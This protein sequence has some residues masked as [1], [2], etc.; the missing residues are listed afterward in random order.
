MYFIS[1]FHVAGFGH[2]DAWYDGLTFDFRDRADDAGS[3]THLI[4]Q[5]PNGTG[6]TSLLGAM[7]SVFEPDQNQFLPKLA[8]PVRQ[9]K[10]YLDPG[11][12]PSLL[13]IE[14]KTDG[15][16]NTVVIGNVSALRDGAS[17]EVS[18][19]YFSYRADANGGMFDGRVSFDS[20]P[21]L[22]DAPGRLDGW[23]QWLAWL[24][25][26]RK[27]A[28]AHDWFQTDNQT[29]WNRNLTKNFS[30]D[31]ALYRKM[32]QFSRVE[33]G[34]D[35][36][37]LSFKTQTD[38]LREFMALTLPEELLADAL[39]LVHSESAR[40]KAKPQRE[41]ERDAVIRLEAAFA[42]FAEQAAVLRAAEERHEAIDT[43]LRRLAAAMI[44]IHL[45]Q[46]KRQNEL[47][48]LVKEMNSRRTGA[49]RQIQRLDLNLD[50]VRETAFTMNAKMLAQNAEEMKRRRDEARRS[51]LANK[52]AQH[53][54]GIELLEQ[55]LGDVQA[56]I[57]RADAGLKNWRDEATRV[58]TRYACAVTVER[59]R[60]DLER[61][62]LKQDL[63]HH[64]ASIKNLE[65]TRT[66]LLERRT[67]LK[68][69]ADGLEREL[70]ALRGLALTLVREGWLAS[71][72]ELAPDALARHQAAVAEAE[73][74]FEAAETR[75]QAARSRVEALQDAAAQARQT[76][77]TAKKAV[78][79]ATELESTISRQGERLRAL[80]GYALLGGAGDLLAASVASELLRVERD[81]H[82]KQIRTDADAA[83][84]KEAIEAIDRTRLAPPPPDTLVVAEHL[85]AAGITSAKPHL[86]YLAAVVP[87]RE[88]ATAVYL[89]DPARFAGVAIANPKELEAARRVRF[90]GLSLST[91]V[92][93]SA[94]TNVAQAPATPDGFVVPPTRAA[95]YHLDSAEAE[96]QTLE[97]EYTRLVDESDQVM[98]SLKDLAALRK[99][100][101]EVR[102][103]AGGRTLADLRYATQ[104]A[105][106]LERTAASAKDR[107]ETA[108]ADAK[109]EREEADTARRA[110]A[111]RKQDLDRGSHRLTDY[112]TR[113]EA[114]RDQREDLAGIRLEQPQ[115]EESFTKTTAELQEHRARADAV[116]ERRGELN[117]EI[118][119]LHQTL[120][121]IAYKQDVTDTVL[122]E[123]QLVPKPVAD[124]RSDY[125]EAVRLLDMEASQK[126]GPLREQEVSTKTA[127][128]ERR[129]EYN[130]HYGSLEPSEM[131]AFRQ[132]DHD[133]EERRL[134]TVEDSSDREREAFQSQKAVVDSGLEQL[135][136]ERR[137]KGRAQ[138][139]LET[140]DTVGAADKRVHELEIEIANQ[141]KIEQTAAAQLH[142]HQSQLTALTPIVKALKDKIDRHK[143]ED[144]IRNAAGVV[145]IAQAE[146]LAFGDLVGDEFA[147]TYDAN[148]DVL[149]EVQRARTESATRYGQFTALLG[150]PEITRSLK[151][152]MIAGLTRNS[153]EEAAAEAE[154]LAHMLAARR[155]TI[156]EDLKELN[157]DFTRI[158]REIE[159]VADEASSALKKAGTKCVPD[160]I[161]VYG[162]Q[163]ILKLAT[164]RLAVPQDVRFARLE[165]YL[166][167]LV[168]TEQ[169]PTT[170]AQLAAEAVLEFTQQDHL[171]VRILKVTQ[172]ETLDYLPVHALGS[173][174]GEK[175]VAAVLLWALIAKLKRE[176]GREKKK[177]PVG[178]LIIDNIF[179]QVTHEALLRLLRSMS[180]ALKVQ[181]I[182]TSLY[183]DPSIAAVFPKMLHLRPHVGRHKT[184]HR[185]HVEFADRQLVNL[186]AKLRAAAENAQTASSVPAEAGAA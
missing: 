52:A 129:Q 113:S 143:A 102:A 77:Q 47:D 3:P 163:P 42:G 106:Q 120:A 90:D 176:H 185:R 99:D 9:F 21:G 30:V 29:D 157:A 13:A 167:R 25:T 100:L 146:E 170:G 186:E 49:Q 84:V 2:K 124:A 114:A 24:K 78:V 101:E 61:G 122:R 151:P 165:G 169:L 172:H 1:R 133:A 14:L 134:A 128:R 104:E 67:L 183:E 91:P 17:G 130:R 51:R 107:S 39:K 20:L 103:R 71:E 92:V 152:L 75:E 76:H 65:S 131:D 135:R 132:V 82:A 88:Q 41:A 155:M 4:L 70:A 74:A 98:C 79:A 184:T 93:V 111:K 94:A 28:A 48:E 136:N 139:S 118:S 60:L 164:D 58:G 86:G 177:A 141:K 69:R 137:A 64:E 23:D 83:R 12:R 171:N 16:S 87:E 54:I 55:R 182:F 56:E 27:R 147:A 85:R 18:R 168:T 80:P 5:A 154:H 121:G 145:W 117:T 158:V 96:R 156:I 53:V 142:V 46:R 125:E 148:V 123:C 11:G 115:V 109:R 35:K 144:L 63:E 108:L 138:D 31:V 22:T 72:D 150:D 59:K 89:S 178:P 34:V 73:A 37:F 26:M 105:E 43:R 33:G 116:R 179:A 173:S 8:D 50:S 19:H 97:G 66:E 45:Q 57:D 95:T 175:A 140:F 10:G 36:G 110:A 166:T 160:E 181:C 15:S 44:E 161:R 62:L 7:F 162:G 68:T 81:Y 119:A 180:E 126:T 40:M 149:G 159:R 153:Y 38:F 6:K 32:L 112:A 127:I 174:G